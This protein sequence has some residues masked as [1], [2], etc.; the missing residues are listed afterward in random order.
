MK[1]MKLTGIRQIEMMDVPDVEIKNDTDVLVQLKAVG[2]C[3]SDVHYYNTGRI[4]SQVVEFP[5][6]VGHECAGVVAGVGSKVTGLKAGDRIAVDPAVSCWEC[7]QCKSG[8][9]HTCRKLLFLGCPGQIEGC[10]SE[11]IVMPQE[12]C[13]KIKDSMSFQQAAISEPLAIGVYAVK[14]SIPMQDAKIGILGS[15]PIG[16]SVLLPAKMQGV[17][18]VY[19]TDKI[20]SRLDVA[21]KC[22]ADWC[23]NPD[24]SDIVAD[25]TAKEPL[26][27][28]VVFEC[29]GQQDALDQAIELLKPGGK[30]IMI[31]IPEVDRV[32]FSIDKL[33]RKEICIQNIRRQVGCVQD[34]LDMIDNGLDVDMM[35]THH[36]TFEQTKD[37]FDLV[38]AYKDGVVKA[39]IEF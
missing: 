35:A 24:S 2:V 34:A 5:F 39:M 14:K 32:S 3:G 6:A 22:G 29:C 36:F 16:L 13:Y 9:H 23:G 1:A 15:G 28:D 37:A 18:K 38:A 21:K 30:L 25:I 11:Y 19:V 17:G 31:G 26:L 20:D 10:L 33:R 8:R 4:G 7:D 27:L 12:S